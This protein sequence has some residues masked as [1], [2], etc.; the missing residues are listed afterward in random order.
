MS[1]IGLI[2]DGSILVVNGTIASVGPT[3]RI[4]NLAEAR[5]AVEINATGRVVLPAWVDS[6][7]SLTHLPLRALDYPSG[8]EN[9]RLSPTRVNELAEQYFRTTSPTRL[10]HQARRGTETA[11]RNGTLSLET[12]YG[13]SLSEPVQIKALKIARAVDGQGCT[14]QQSLVATGA[15]REYFGREDDYLDW[16]CS[17]FLPK[18][19]ARALCNCVEV[20]C[21]PLTFSLAHARRFLGCARRLGFSVKLQS[22]KASLMGTVA[23]CAEAPVRA[24]AGLSECETRDAENLSRS[25]TLAT[26]LPGVAFRG[27]QRKYASGRE[28]I[29]L[30]VPVALGSGGDGFLPPALNMQGTIA[31]ACSHMGMTVEEAISAAT[32][33]AAHVIQRAPSVG[34]LEFG[35]DADILLLNVPDYREIPYNMGTNLV[36]MTVRRGEPIYREGPISLEGGT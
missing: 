35:K 6:H 9:R 31:V 20:S 19:Q 14:V 33:N 29:D 7:T 34:T 13:F 25:G 30:G 8:E 23:L 4:E 28:L 10:E 12:K 3:R 11:I 1:E 2:E 32:I 27:S 36:E 5:K 22:E 26:L 15:P 17:E 24:I 18:V 21:D 16:L